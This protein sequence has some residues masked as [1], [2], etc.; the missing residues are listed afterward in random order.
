MATMEEIKQKLENRLAYVQ[1]EIDFVNSDKGNVYK[2]HHYCGY[3]QGLDGTFGEKQ[4]L[5]KMIEFVSEV[6]EHEYKF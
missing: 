3:L 4:F 5:T 1:R 2:H 6:D